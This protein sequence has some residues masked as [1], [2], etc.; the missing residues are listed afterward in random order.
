MW[1]T[2]TSNWDGMGFFVGSG[3]IVIHFLRSMELTSTTR[4]S[5]AHLHQ[6]SD[7]NQYA[8][9]AHLNFF[10]EDLREAVTHICLAL[11]VQYF[12]LLS[13]SLCWPFLQHWPQT[14]RIFRFDGPN[15]LGALGNFCRDKRLLLQHIQQKKLKS[16]YIQM[17]SETDV[18]ERRLSVLH[19]TKV[20][21]VTWVSWELVSMHQNIFASCTILSCVMPVKAPPN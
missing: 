9:K 5:F 11:A 3:R 18:K 17:W 1:G 21:N 15:V 7:A 10:N 16:L 19:Y 6:I 13:A 12:L 14:K 2:P 8:C 4:L 20:P